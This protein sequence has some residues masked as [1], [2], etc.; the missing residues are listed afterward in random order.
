MYWMRI[1]RR[2][3]VSGKKV[4]PTRKEYLL[5]VLTKNKNRVYSPQ[6]LLDI[7]WDNKLLDLPTVE[8]RIASLRKKLG[9][10]ASKMRKTVSDY[11]Y[12]L[13]GK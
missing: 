8:T 11:G 6:E 2:L 3:S 5:K 12:K 7:V 13:E 1:L 4:K 10:K 9:S